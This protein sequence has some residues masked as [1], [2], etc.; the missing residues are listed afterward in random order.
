MSEMH[1]SKPIDSGFR[2]GIDAE[3]V[4]ASLEGL[5]ARIRAG[6][7]IVKQIAHERASFVGDWEGERLT[8][9]FH[10]KEGPKP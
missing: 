1:F 10:S 7:A 9:N 4:A 8:V 3:I 2:L 6:T 5:A